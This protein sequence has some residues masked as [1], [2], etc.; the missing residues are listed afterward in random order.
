MR[1]G[2]VG[3]R[4]LPWWTGYGAAMITWSTLQVFLEAGHEVVFYLISRDRDIGLATEEKQAYLAQL[5][6]EVLQKHGTPEPI[7]HECSDE[8]LVE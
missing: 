6:L 7:I 3:W 1:I 2:Y 5:A 8:D 4:H